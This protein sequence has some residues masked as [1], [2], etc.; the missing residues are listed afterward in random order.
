MA[1]TV[2]FAISLAPE[3]N[4]VNVLLK[5]L[6]NIA[7]IEKECVPLKRIES[8]GIRN[9]LMTRQ[10]SQKHFQDSALHPLLHLLIRVR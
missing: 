9:D 5:D 7:R 4:F 8:A 1:D 2:L 10:F 6:P 3:V